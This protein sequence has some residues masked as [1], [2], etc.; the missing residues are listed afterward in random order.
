MKQKIITILTVTFFMFA[1]G[2]SVKVP[3]L[4]N[5]LLAGQYDNLLKK[6]NA[7]T[8]R[9]NNLVDKLNAQVD[10]YNGLV[11][12]YNAQ[13]RRN[14]DNDSAIQTAALNLK[15]LDEAVAEYKTALEE[16]YQKIEAKQCTEARSTI[17]DVVKPHL[18]VIATKA[19]TLTQ[20]TL[21]T[22][23]ERMSTDLSSYKDESKDS[24]KDRILRTKAQISSGLT[25]IK[26]FSLFAHNQL[27]AEFNENCVDNT[28]GFTT[29]EV[30]HD[31]GSAAHGISA[32]SVVTVDR[33]GEREVI[34]R[35]EL[36]TRYSGVYDREAYS[37]FSTIADGSGGFLGFS[38]TPKLF[39][40]MVDIVLQNII[41]RTGT[42]TDVAIVLDTTASMGDDID[43]VKSNMNRRLEK[44]KEKASAI[45][46]R[47][48]LVLYRDQGDEYIVKVVS[49]FTG[50][51]DSINTAIQSI[52]VAGGGN[53]PEAVVDALDAAMEDLSWTPGAS[54]SVLL[55]GDAPGHPLSY[56]GL[57][58]EALI[59]N[60]KKADLG[61]IVYPILVS[62]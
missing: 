16:A 39:S 9:Y 12:E 10:Q 1:C 47:L 5:E 19:N 33:S 55:I 52:T 56:S 3:N 46:L 44:I 28:V 40:Q 59:D 15:A 32:D 53:H 14:V 18:D 23:L 17:M 57:S 60:Y 36:R 38:P 26:S 45:G 62:R 34:S 27:I 11:K 6:F 31:A 7:E 22:A 41:E 43:N 2:D 21:E 42:Q 51:I 37:H 24:A 35:D 13:T 8:E 54:R 30:D 4:K 50:N 49:D 29:P 61:I 20:G 58:T 25:G 48:S